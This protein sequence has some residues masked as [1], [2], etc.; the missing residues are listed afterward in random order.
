MDALAG[1]QHH[2]PVRV[3]IH[4]E[5][6]DDCFGQFLVR[7]ICDW[8]AVREISHVTCDQ[9]QLERTSTRHRAVGRS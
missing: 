3:L 1:P 2:V 8:G 4:L 5:K 6:L 7:V 9:P